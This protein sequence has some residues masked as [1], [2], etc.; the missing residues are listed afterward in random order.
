MNLKYSPKGGL[1]ET[2]V[3]DSEQSVV[4]SIKDQGIGMSSEDLDKIFVKFYRVDSSNTSI[5]GTGLGANIMK[6]LIE[7][8]GGKIIIN[9]E[10]GK[11]TEVVF[12]IPKESCSSA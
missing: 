4:V 2:F 5:N 8:H 12:N 3:S 9:S 11:G 1:I 6:Y 10:L 7:A